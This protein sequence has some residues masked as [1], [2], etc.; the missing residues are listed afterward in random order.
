MDHYMRSKGIHTEHRR[1]EERIDE[2]REKT[3]QIEHKIT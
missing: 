1:N 3:V 2:G